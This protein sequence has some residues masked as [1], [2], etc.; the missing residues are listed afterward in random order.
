MHNRL[1]LLTLLVAPC[2]LSACVTTETY[3][4]NPRFRQ[5][6][7]RIQTVTVLPADV[8]VYQIDAGG[9]REPME[10]WCSQAK[11]NILRAVENQLSTKMRTIVDVLTEELLDEKK[12]HWE[13]TR[14]LYSAVSAMVFLHTYQNPNIPNHYFAE[15]LKNFDYSLGSDVQSLA[16]GASMLLF[17]E[18]EDHIWTGGRR[19]LQGLGALLGIAAGV[20]TGVVIIPYM[21]GG[22]TIQAALVDSATGDLLWINAVRAGAGTDLRDATSATNMVNDLFKDFPPAHESQ[23]E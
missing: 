23:S 18:A 3:R 2:L 21:G 14:A 11:N 10:E 16:P 12:S 19:A 17:L 5:Q 20:A 1:A 8:K 9:I 15:K 6:S 13:E 22:T 7:E 4:V